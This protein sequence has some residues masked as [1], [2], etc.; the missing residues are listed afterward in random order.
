MF[1]VRSAMRYVLPFGAGGN[2]SPLLTVTSGP[3][4]P[5]GP[6]TWYWAEAG[7][8]LPGRSGSLFDM[9]ILPFWLENRDDA[10]TD[11][12]LGTKNLTK[13]FR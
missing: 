12:A 13:T 1:F 5:R 8:V 4:P 10:R 11:D 6:M 2:V 7:A 9:G 3:L